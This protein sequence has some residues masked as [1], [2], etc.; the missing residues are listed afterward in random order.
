MGTGGQGPFLSPPEDF[1]TARN[2]CYLQVKGPA[3][4]EG[5]FRRC[6]VGVGGRGGAQVREPRRGRGGAARYA[7]L[8]GAEP[9]VRGPG[10]EG[11]SRQVRGPQRSGGAGTPGTAD[12]GRPVFPAGRGTPAVRARAG[13]RGQ[14]PPPP[15][16][17][18]PGA[19]ARLPPRPNFAFPAS[20]GQAGDRKSP[21]GPSGRNVGVPGAPTPPAR[22][23]NQRRTPASLGV[24]G[25][26]SLFLRRA[27]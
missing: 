9:Q 14:T 17:A 7:G 4:E 16:R 12:A 23:G 13:K 18:R 1:P 2:G 5:R 20:E 15:G 8:R 25:G 22:C 26:D 19:A 3:P 6:Q 10:G 27:K 11:G 24:G 21:C